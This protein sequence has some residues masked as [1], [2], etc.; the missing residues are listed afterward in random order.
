METDQTSSSTEKAAKEE[1]DEWPLN[2]QSDNQ[3]IS[4]KQDTSESTEMSKEM[5]A[6]LH[7]N[8][9]DEVVEE[10]LEKI[11]KVVVVGDGTC[12]KTSLCT[13][14]AQRDYAGRYIQVNFYTKISIPNFRQSELTSFRVEFHFPTIATCYS[15]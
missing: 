10:D 4:D 11:I 14:F 6:L 3:D 7:K 2:K 8:D 1:P 12:G 13:R 9:D 15:R 5:A